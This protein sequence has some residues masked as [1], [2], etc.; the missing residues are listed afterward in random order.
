MTHWMPLAVGLL[1]AL[2]TGKTSGS[3]KYYRPLKHVSTTIVNG[4]RRMV[5]ISYST[6][7][8]IRKSASVLSN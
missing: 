1:Q 3:L 8:G 4:A 5:S 6:G 2:T 7:F